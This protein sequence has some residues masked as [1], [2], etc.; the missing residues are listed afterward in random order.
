MPIRNKSDM[1]DISVDI[2]V[3]NI[4]NIDEKSQTF[5]V[6]AFLEVKWTNQF[7]TWRSKDYG[8]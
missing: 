6:R 2:F 8:G 3:M 4:D 5:S 1:I 7:L